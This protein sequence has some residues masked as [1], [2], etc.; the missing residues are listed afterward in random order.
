M[1]LGP[2]GSG[3]RLGTPKRL[4]GVRLRLDSGITGTPWAP[5]QANAVNARC[6]VLNWPNGPQTPP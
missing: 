3:P 5:I 2:E 6:G 4:G 1:G